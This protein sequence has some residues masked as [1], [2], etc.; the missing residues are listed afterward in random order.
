MKSCN[1]PPPRCAEQGQ[2]TVEYTIVVLLSVTVL[3]ARPDVI[4][5][6]VRVLRDIYLAFVYAI[7]LSSLP[8]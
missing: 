6:L 5:E 4:V 1:V 3:V 8:I 2:A 7:S